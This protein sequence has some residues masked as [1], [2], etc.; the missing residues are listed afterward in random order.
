MPFFV[1]ALFHLH[2]NTLYPSLPL[3]DTPDHDFSAFFLSKC[4]CPARSH[5][6]QIGLHPSYAP[7]TPVPITCLVLVHSL[8]TRNIPLIIDLHSVTDQAQR[9][10][11]AIARSNG[12]IKLASR[13]SDT[14]PAILT[15]PDL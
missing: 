15:N 6:W 8:P 10:A 9:T 5:L 2:F 3:I 11:E 4:P 13:T 14:H 7:I 1:E 12:R